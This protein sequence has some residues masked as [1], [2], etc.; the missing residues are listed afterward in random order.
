[1]VD[2]DP[3]EVGAVLAAAIR[4]TTGEP[5]LEWDMPADGP[6]AGAVTCARWARARKGGARRR[7]RTWWC[8]GT[9]RRRS[10]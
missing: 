4:T 6:A 2:G 8:A 3:E 5:A 10:R 7:C 1:M 9:R